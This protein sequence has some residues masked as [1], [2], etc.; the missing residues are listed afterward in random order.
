MNQKKTKP[1]Y[2]EKSLNAEYIFEKL[3]NFLSKDDII[4]SETGVS[5]FTVAKFK[6]I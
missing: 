2:I 3:E 6:K 5:M 1:L 4:F